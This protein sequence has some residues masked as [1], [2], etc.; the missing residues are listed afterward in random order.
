MYIFKTE[1]PLIPKRVYE[2]LPVVA[3]QT[4]F[5]SYF[6]DNSAFSTGLRTGTI[7]TTILTSIEHKTNMQN[8]NKKEGSDYMSKW[9]DRCF[10]VGTSAAVLSHLTLGPVFSV[11]SAALAAHEMPSD[12]EQ[13]IKK[14]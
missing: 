10:L 1:K 11:V 5:I 3:A 7:V 13:K 6:L 9:G 12:Q 2:M 4:L 14:S 8:L